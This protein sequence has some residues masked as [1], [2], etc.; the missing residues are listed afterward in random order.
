MAPKSTE[1]ARGLAARR[2]VAIQRH[3]RRF[4]RSLIRSSGF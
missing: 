1:V 3:E 4:L 2:T